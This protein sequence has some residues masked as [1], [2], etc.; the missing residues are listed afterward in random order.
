M[1]AGGGVPGVMGYVPRCGPSGYTMTTVRVPI[2]LKFI[3]VSL[4]GV[5]RDAFS[6]KTVN[7]R[8]FHEFHENRQ[9]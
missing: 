5:G 7:F 2:S 4:A 9:F 1:G 8:V 3:E 6:D